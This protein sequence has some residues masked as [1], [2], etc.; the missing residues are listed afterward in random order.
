MAY[1]WTTE[2]Q[3]HFDREN[4]NVLTNWPK[5]NARKVPSLISTSP[6]T[7]KGC[8]Q[9]GF[10]IDDSSVVIKA[11]KLELDRKGRLEELKL[12]VR[13]LK[14]LAALDYNDNHAVRNDIPTYLVKD[15]VE[16]VKSYLAKVADTLLVE[17]A[18]VH[19]SRVAETVYI[20]LIVTHPAVSLVSCL[21]GVGFHTRVAC[22]LAVL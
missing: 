18:S 16:I 1:A 22:L 5:T 9:W 19:G 17:I 13:T 12:L 21:L 15:D 3:P 10:D 7:K 6:S 8:R 4:I 11:V 14:G 2:S 20:D